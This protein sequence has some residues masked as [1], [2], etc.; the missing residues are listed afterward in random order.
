MN[1]LAHPALIQ[2]SEST[3]CCQLF[4]QKI[5][6][7]FPRSLKVLQIKGFNLVALLEVEKVSNRVFSKFDVLRL[8][9]LLDTLLRDYLLT[10]KKHIL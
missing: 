5:L 4:S 7:I 6:N 3:I 2:Y 10:L 8:W 1:A 9:V